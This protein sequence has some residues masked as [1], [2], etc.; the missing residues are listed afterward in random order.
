MNF[1]TAEFYSGSCYRRE[2]FIVAVN[3]SLTVERN[4]SK[5]TRHYGLGHFFLFISVFQYQVLRY[6]IA[7][8]DEKSAIRISRNHT[9]SS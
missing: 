7:V 6:K 5:S 2:L 1:I 3:Y 8:I 9:L 4:A